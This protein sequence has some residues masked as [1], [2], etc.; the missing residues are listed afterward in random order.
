MIF[1]VVKQV[2]FVV[3]IGSGLLSFLSPANAQ[4]YSSIPSTNYIILSSPLFPTSY[5]ECAALAEEFREESRTLSAQ[6]QQCLDQAPGDESVGTTCSKIGCQNLHTAMSE[7]T[8]KGAREVSVCRSRVQDHLTKKR[9]E[10]DQRAQIKADRDS[11]RGHTDRSAEEQQQRESDAQ[12]E[13]DRQEAEMKVEQAQREA[14]YKKRQQAEALAKAYR[15]AVAKKATDIRNEWQQRI[16][17]TIPDLASGLSNFMDV[18]TRLF[19]GDPS[20]SVSQV[21]IAGDQLTERVTSAYDWIS[22]PL[23]TLSDR[24]TADAIQVLRADNR[25]QKTDERLHTIIRGVRQ[26]NNIAH[27]SNP[28]V[29][30]I[31]AAVYDELESHFF[32]LNGELDK[33]KSDIGLVGTALNKKWTPPAK[34]PFVASSTPR[35]KA[36]EPTGNPFLRDQEKNIEGNTE[37][38]RSDASGSVKSPNPFRTSTLDPIESSS[39][40]SLREKE[41][42][43]DCST[44]IDI[45]SEEKCFIQNGKAGIDEKTSQ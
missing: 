16:E 10:E 40:F 29:R 4:F 2:N 13:R 18:A 6:H 37:R 12:A 34:N 19:R 14:Q 43:Q 11:E 35:R 41:V 9:R 30:A 42:G 8:K 23:E 31:N 17:N 28:F 1:N 39:S 21:V 38:F 25:T 5:D 45:I 33:L 44:I 27:E 20:L 3:F 32:W 26:L 36:S 7:A 15:Q 22:A 24:L